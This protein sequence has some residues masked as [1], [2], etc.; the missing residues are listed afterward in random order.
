[1]ISKSSDLD[2]KTTLDAKHGLYITSNL[3]NIL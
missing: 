1:L 2:F 3:R